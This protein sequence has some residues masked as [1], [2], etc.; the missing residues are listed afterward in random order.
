LTSSTRLLWFSGQPRR[1]RAAVLAVLA[2]LTLVGGSG[3]LLL[4]SG[5]IPRL[6][7]L[8]LQIPTTT[9]TPTLTHT[10]SPTPTYTL[11]CTPTSTPEMIQALTIGESVQG[12]PLEV[13]RIGWGERVLVIAAAIHG[14]EPNTAYL[15]GKLRD[16]FADSISTLPGG[17]AVYFLP[18][19]NPD[20]LA[21]GR[22][23]NAHTVDL[24]R[25]W[26]TENWRPNPEGPYE[27]VL[28]QGGGLA[29][30]SEP[31]TAALAG[32]LWELKDEASGGVI[33]LFYHSAYAGGSVQPGYATD[34][35]VLSSDPQSAVVA[36]LLADQLDYN[37]LTKF[38]WYTVTG[39]EIGW[40]AENGLTCAEIE[41][42][43]AGTPTEAEIDLHF[44]ALWQLI[45]GR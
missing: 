43:T 33:A 20:G 34:G 29:P 22:R 21:S 37:Y 10:P 12:R 24:N 9:P 2:I 30:F 7:R 23:F 45:G 15:A 31:E 26:R 35:D 44:R 13:T 42:P 27:A 16:R 28:P 17:V 36:G 39:N 32:W 41:L 38:P 18:E 25:N 1:K 6:A 40:C 19:I 11:T 8:A 5:R 3:W 4:G 14:S